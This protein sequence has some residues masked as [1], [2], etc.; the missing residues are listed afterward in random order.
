MP[1]DRPHWFQR[2]IEAA[3]DR[4]NGA[5]I[6]ARKAAQAFVLSASENA[7]ESDIRDAL[8]LLT[9]K[10]SAMA[11]VLSLAA[12]LT[13]A[14]QKG[15]EGVGTI[16]EA[17]VC[18]L[19]DADL[20][21]RDELS[22]SAKT[23]DSPWGFFSNSST[24]F[25]G[26]EALAGEGLL[27]RACVAESR[28]GGEGVEAARKLDQLGWDVVLMPDTRFNDLVREK[29]IAR[30]ILGCDACDDQLFVNKVGSGGLAALARQRSIP[31]E[32]WTSTH[33]ILARRTL[34][35]MFVDGPQGDELAAPGRVVVS[36]PL[37]GLGNLAD[38]SYIRTEKGV[39]NHRELADY[40]ATLTPLE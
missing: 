30:L 11:I 35:T 13:A 6:I 8:R 14:L 15:R 34:E 23:I 27:G 2:V 7:P 40:V 10:Q 26:V 3:E 5:A 20:Y 39:W 28:P 31:V 17:W 19:L 37:F 22:K 12:E 25:S 18:S 16:A 1:G 4:E 29:G 24:V 9:A 36:Q 33:K 21:F 38:V 32:L